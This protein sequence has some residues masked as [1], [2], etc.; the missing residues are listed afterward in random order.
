LRQNTLLIPLLFIVRKLREI[1]WQAEG[2]VLLSFSFFGGWI[3][4]AF[5]RLTPG[6]SRLGSAAVLEAL[7]LF[8]AGTES[9]RE[10][11]LSPAVYTVE[12]VHG[13]IGHPTGT[14][15]SQST[16]ASGES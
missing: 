13:Y 7:R 8:S 2:R 3:S 10:L 16:R 11:F 14:Q 4:L 15:P 1:D 12:Y 9:N 6:E 5:E